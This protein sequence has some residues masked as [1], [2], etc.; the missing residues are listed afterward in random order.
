MYRYLVGALCLI[1]S[2][3]SFANTKAEEAT[4]AYA[5]RDFTPE[6]VKFAQ[7]ATSLYAE[8]VADETDEL[9]KLNL[10]VNQ[11]SAHYF[12]GTAMQGKEERKAQHQTAMDISDAIMT[13]LGVDPEKAHEMS[14]AEVTEILNKYEADKELIVAEAMYSKGINLGQWGRLNGISSSIGQLPT[15]LGLMDRIEMLGYESIHE[16]GPYRTIGRVNFILPKLLGGDLKK[17]AKF[18]QDAY[19]KTLATGQRYSTNGYNNVYLAETLYKQGKENQGKKLINIFLAADP[20]TLKEGSEPENRE[21]LKI[22][23]EL[24]DKWQ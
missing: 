13:S 14:E 12:L 24:H 17:S 21:A 7:K 18:L 10:M 19:R 6:G 9:E 8:A 16:Y 1:L 2:I 5:Q 15:V 20:K 4:A 3:Q 22:A 11:A 23:Q